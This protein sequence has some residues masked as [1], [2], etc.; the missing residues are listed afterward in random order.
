MLEMQSYRKNKINLADYDYE[1]DIRNRLL[2]ANFSSTDILVLEEILYSPLKFPI[3]RITK[4][5]D[6]DKKTVEKTLK[7]L[8]KTELFSIENDEVIVDKEM[9]KYFE[10]QM[11]KFEDNFKPGMDF[12]QSLLK[13]VP[14]HILPNWYPIPRTSNNIFN[15]LI[16]KYLQTPQIFQRYLSEL[17]FTDPALAGIVSDVL[18]DPNYQV[19]SKT[20]MKKYKLEQ[21][22]FEEYMLYLEFNF[23][24]CLVYKKHGDEWAEDVTLFQEWRDYL[25]FLKDTQPKG[26]ENFSKIQR[27]R[28]DNFSFVK[29]MTAIM[30]LA[31]K[32]NLQLSI[33]DDEKWVPEKESALLIAKICSD[34]DLESEEGLTHFN[35]YIS[36]IIQK[37]L[38]LNLAEISKRQLKPLPNAKEW[39]ALP[40]EKRTITTYRTTLNRYAFSEFPPEICS[41]RNIHEIEKSISR[42]IGSGWVYFDNFMEGIIAPISEK[43]KMVLTKT[44]RYWKYAIPDYSEDEIA[45]IKLV[46]FEW[47]FEGGIVATGSHQGRECFYVT[48]LGQSMFG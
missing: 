46:I 9:R 14:I 6:L 15:S 28:P 29:D 48:D 5:L 32:K 16:E 43:S 33:N 2:M 23:V 17:N 41:E 42:I 7:N 26:I 37:L 8:L 24:C 22:Q 3:S 4:S 31:Q 13:K 18:N 45:L 44:G 1:K 34:F 36:S 19:S 27:K 39:L 38:F 35:E 20:I 10:A 25:S 12:L 40:I 30:Q 47:L 21:T 11:L